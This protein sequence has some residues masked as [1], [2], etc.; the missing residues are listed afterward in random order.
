[1]KSNAAHKLFV[2]NLKD[3]LGEMSAAELADRLGVSRPAVS[4]WLKNKGSP[5]LNQVS[6]VAKVFGVTVARMFAPVKK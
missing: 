5:R 1:M 6:E 2:A 4:R 3:L